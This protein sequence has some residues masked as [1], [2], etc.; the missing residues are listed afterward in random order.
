MNEVIDIF[1]FSV[2]FQSVI[3][4]YLFPETTASLRQ[5]TRRAGGGL[6][7]EGNSKPLGKGRLALPTLTPVAALC[8]DVL[9]QVH[10]T[11]SE[12]PTS[13]VLTLLK[14][15]PHTRKSCC[16]CLVMFESGPSHI[17]TL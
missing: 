10:L 9:L 14:A 5:I 11:Q 1:L 12:W 15:P 16:N 6:S 8:P 17:G 2:Q 7:V 3:N 4:F 13:D